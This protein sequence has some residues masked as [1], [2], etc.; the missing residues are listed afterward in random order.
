MNSDRPYTFSTGLDSNLG[1]FTDEL[2]QSV[3]VSGDSHGS[4]EPDDN[5]FFAHNTS[6]DNT[7]IDQ[8]LDD[9]IPA[10]FIDE[11]EEDTDDNEK[12]LG[13]AV[14]ESSGKALAH[15]VDRVASVILGLIAKGDAKDYRADKTEMS[16]LQQAFTDFMLETGFQMSPSTNLFVAILSIYGFKA[17]GA[18]QDRKNNEQKAL[19]SQPTTITVQPQPK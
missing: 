7:F 1:A 13:K 11:T 5:S 16:D 6:T 12:H 14:A 18:L 2:K 10:D 9:N 4:Q 17:M 3:P 15:S 19:Q 8:T